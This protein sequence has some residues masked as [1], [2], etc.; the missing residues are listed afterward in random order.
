MAKP[1]L[2]LRP[3][4]TVIHDGPMSKVISKM[5]VQGGSA[6]LSE[7]RFMRFKQNTGMMLLIGA[8]SF[9]FKDKPDFEV[10]L[11]DIKS[12]ARGKQGLNKNVIMMTLTD[13]T[14]YKLI[15]SKF[16]KWMHAFAEAYAANGRFTFNELGSEQWAIQ[17]STHTRA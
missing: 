14:E 16:D 8:I 3:D 7:Q 15:C 6:Y 9:L 2:E 12:I 4:E 17:P 11:G 10:E 13:G 1:N 5:S